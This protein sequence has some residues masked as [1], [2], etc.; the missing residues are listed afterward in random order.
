MVCAWP[1]FS[2]AHP[3]IDAKNRTSLLE[4][5]RAYVTDLKTH[6]RKGLLLCELKA[7]HK[8]KYGY[9][10]EIKHLPSLI[11]IQ[12]QVMSSFARRQPLINELLSR[13]TLP[14]DT[15]VIALASIENTRS[16]NQR[17]HDMA[18][19]MTTPQYIACTNRAE[20]QLGG[21][22]ADQGRTFIRG[23]G[24]EAADFVLTDTQPHTAMVINLNATADTLRRVQVLTESLQ[25]AGDRVWVWNVASGLGMPPLPP[26]KPVSSGH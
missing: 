20:V 26:L 3:R 15:R 8:S 12:P 6:Q 10:L 9:S 1:A 19:L 23:M 11:F 14:N 16:G 24:A 2:I 18:G 7:V 21:L 4:Q 22:L 5:W 25:N 13:G 17:V